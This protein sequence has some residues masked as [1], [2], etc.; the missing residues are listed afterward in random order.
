MNY[1]TNTNTNQPSLL[2]NTEASPLLALCYVAFANDVG[3]AN[4]YE[5]KSTPASEE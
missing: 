1:F 3:Y 4:T 2:L 5:L